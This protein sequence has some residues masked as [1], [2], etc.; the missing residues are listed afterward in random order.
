MLSII[1][2]NF[3]STS[4]NTKSST[5]LSFLFLYPTDSVELLQLTIPL[6]INLYVILVRAPKSKTSFRIY[7][8]NSHKNNIPSSPGP[9]LCWARQPHNRTIQMF[10]TMKFKHEAPCWSGINNSWIQPLQTL[11]GCSCFTVSKRSPSSAICDA[12]GCCF[13]EIVYVGGYKNFSLAKF[14]YK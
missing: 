6:L 13:N 7:F 10:I 4:S 9:R 11:P 1:L 3:I 5:N 12:V 8:N 2:R 14:S